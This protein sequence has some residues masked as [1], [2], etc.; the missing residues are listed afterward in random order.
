ME[1]HCDHWRVHI[2]VDKM[3]KKSRL[4]AGIA[5]DSRWR[6]IFRKFK[7]RKIYMQIF[8]KLW[9]HWAFVRRTFMTEAVVVL[10]RHRH[11]L[12]IF[13]D[14]FAQWLCPCTTIPFACLRVDATNYNQNHTRT[15]QSPMSLKF[16]FYV[17][18]CEHKNTNDTQCVICVC[19]MYIVQ[20][21]I[22]VQHCVACGV[23]IVEQIR[24]KLN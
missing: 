17:V 2:C 21:S 10:H 6:R 18:D 13:M 1:K 8:P 20:P 19:L 5:P 4:C 23:Y 22:N 15:H 16:K 24:P 14:V 11:E 12:K 7:L 9:N 3:S